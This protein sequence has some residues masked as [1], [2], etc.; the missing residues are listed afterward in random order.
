MTTTAPGRPRD[1]RVDRDLHDHL[2]QLLAERGPDGF[3]VDELAVRSQVSKAAIYR[4]YRNRQELV[5]AGFAAV[6]EDM[7]DVSELPVREA[8]VSLLEWVAGAHAAGMTPTWMVGMQRLPG[9]QQLY[10]EKVV[11]PRRRALR[12][13]LQRGVAQGLI[14]PAQDLDVLL[15]CLSAPAILV[16]MHRARNQPGTVELAD[17]VD[18]VLTGAL[19]PAAR[20]SGW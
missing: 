8:L 16:G 15:T 20:A 18:T 3:S 6:N 9:L 7:P 19:S 17:V 5:E 12:D 1:P 11:T 14:D 13:V 2:I 10:A 4:R